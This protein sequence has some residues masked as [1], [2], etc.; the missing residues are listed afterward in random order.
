MNIFDVYMLSNQY[1]ETVGP[2]KHF[3]Y[4]FIAQC[5]LIYVRLDEYGHQS[6]R[7]GRGSPNSVMT[8]LSGSVTLVK[9]GKM[10]YYSRTIRVH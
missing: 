7:Q 10:W 1:I 3:V 4:D 2:E 9:K 5:P 6:Y 8:T